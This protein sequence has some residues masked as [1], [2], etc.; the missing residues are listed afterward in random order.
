MSEDLKCGIILSTSLCCFLLDRSFVY[1]AAIFETIVRRWKP[2]KEDV[3]CWTT[4][5]GRLWA[6]LYFHWCCTFIYIYD[7]VRSGG[8]TGRRTDPEST[9][10]SGAAVKNTLQ[11]NL[12]VAV[13]IS[14]EP[15]VSISMTEPR[16]SRRTLRQ[17]VLCKVWTKAAAPLT[18]SLTRL[19]INLLMKGTFHQVTHAKVGHNVELCPWP[20]ISGVCCRWWRSCVFVTWLYDTQT[21]PER[22]DAHQSGKT[23]IEKI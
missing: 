17:Q 18:A 20:N 19:L 5:H 13:E 6:Q 12:K 11:L 10:G 3:P 14:L 8:T 2:V 9:T 21:F 4:Q 23:E 15:T 7:T 1:T 22:P 16:G